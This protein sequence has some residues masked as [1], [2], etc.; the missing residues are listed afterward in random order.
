[1]P[2]LKTLHENAGFFLMSTFCS[3]EHWILE[4]PCSSFL[5]NRFILSGCFTSRPSTPFFTNQKK[6]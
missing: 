3:R 5:D 4:S 6:Q 1:A 2:S